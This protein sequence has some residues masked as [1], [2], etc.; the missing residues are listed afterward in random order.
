M[1]KD[2]ILEFFN[3]F[4]MDDFTSFFLTLDVLAMLSRPIVVVIFVALG[5]IAV[6]QKWRLILITIL[7]Y[8]ALY[9]YLF[10]TFVVV[11]NSDL[12]S[13]PTFLLF[14]SSFFL[15]TGIGIYKYFISDR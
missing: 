11:K 2:K 12:S 9:G 14:L 13:I 1:T 15:I 10:I 3:T 8:S 5:L 4:N 7:S 6:Y